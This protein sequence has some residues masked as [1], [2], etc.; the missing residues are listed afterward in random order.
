MRTSRALLLIVAAFGFA[1]CGSSST[2]KHPDAHVGGPDGNNSTPDAPTNTP[3]AAPAGLAGFGQACNPQTTPSTCPASATTC[4]ALTSTATNGWCTPSC[5]QTA[6]VAAPGQPT[7]PANGDTACGTAL[8]SAG[9]ATPADGT[10][11]CVIYSQD[12]TDMTKADWTCG[13]LCGTYTP[14]GG[15]PQ[16]FGGCPSGLTCNTTDNLCE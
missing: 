1:A 11:A 6:W 10:P 4:D 16:N 5:G 15:T 13:L 9:G 8:T 2:T 12:Q 14:Q 7:A 3:D